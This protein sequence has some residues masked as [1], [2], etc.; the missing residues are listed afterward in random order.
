[1][2]HMFVYLTVSKFRCIQRSE[3]Q[4]CTQ[5]SFPEGAVS[6]KLL[7]TQAPVEKVPFLEGAPTWSADAN[8]DANKTV[9]H[10]AAQVGHVG[11]ESTLHS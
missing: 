1:M 5:A 11:G 9:V 6:F 8:R 4:L 10:T 2:F 3:T 7:F